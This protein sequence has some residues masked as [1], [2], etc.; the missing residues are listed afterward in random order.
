MKLLM[1]NPNTTRKVTNR[2]AQAARA[3]AS[4]GTEI[5]S[6]TGRFGGK[7]IGSRSENAIAAHACLEL[8]AMHAKGC[9][10]VVLGVSLDTALWELR[11][12][13][14]VPA[15]GM[16]K[17]GLLVASTVGSRYGVLT[18]GARMIP[19]YEELVSIGIS[20]SILPQFRRECTLWVVEATGRLPNPAPGAW[21]C[22]L[23]AGS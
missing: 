6:V 12:Q 15:T 20:N 22:A 18:F 23:P 7:V 13:L 2:V 5:V 16:T 17:A 10:A 9:A 4:P 21:Q 14:A 1:L 19:L 3:A 8:A 11:E